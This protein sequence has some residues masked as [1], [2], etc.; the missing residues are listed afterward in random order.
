MVPIAID[1]FRDDVGGAASK[2]SHPADG[3]WRW[4]PSAELFNF[5]LSDDP[6]SPASLFCVHDHNVGEKVGC[7]KRILVETVAERNS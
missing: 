3:V 2:V 4:T 1:A 5:A 6:H 7:V